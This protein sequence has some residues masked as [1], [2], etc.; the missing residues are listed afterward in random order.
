MS[1][2]FMLLLIFG[3]M[4]AYYYI[5]SGNMLSGILSG[6]GVTKL[7]KDVTSNPAKSITAATDILKVKDIKIPKTSNNSSK[8]LTVSSIK[9]IGKLF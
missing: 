2:L 7:L 3:V 1:D 6:T 4:A 5:T 8:N 9:K